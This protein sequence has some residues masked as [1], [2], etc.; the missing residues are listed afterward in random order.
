MRTGYSGADFDP[1]VIDLILE[2]EDEQIVLVKDG[3]PA[4][5]AGVEIRQD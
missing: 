4:L 2:A 3:V 5:P 1:D